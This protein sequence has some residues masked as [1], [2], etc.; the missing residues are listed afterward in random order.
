MK[1][2]FSNLKY[3]LFKENVSIFMSSIY[4]WLEN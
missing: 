1:L 2:N 4:V 3:E